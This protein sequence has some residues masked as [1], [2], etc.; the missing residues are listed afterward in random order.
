MTPS[1]TTKHPLK[2]SLAVTMV[3]FLITRCVMG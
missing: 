1:S 3:A 2:A